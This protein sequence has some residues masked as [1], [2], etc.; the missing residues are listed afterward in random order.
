VLLAIICIGLSH[1]LEDA[2]L[3]PISA[4]FHNLT[5]TSTVTKVITVTESCLPVRPQIDQILSSIR[6]SREQERTSIL[7]SPTDMMTDTETAT[8]MESRLDFHSQLDQLV[9][10]ALSA[11]AQRSAS[12]SHYSTAT[13]ED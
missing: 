10:S 2:A 11:K 3:E 7:Y 9:S 8:V 12:D 5:P 13:D 4:E 1:V 6:S